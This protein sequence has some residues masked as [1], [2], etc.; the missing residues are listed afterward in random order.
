MLSQQRPGAR[1]ESDRWGGLAADGGPEDLSKE[2]ERQGRAARGPCG[3]GGGGGMVGERGVPRWAS[4]MAGVWTLPS[5]EPADSHHRG[6]LGTHAIMANR[7]PSRL[8]IPWTGPSP[9]PRAAPEDPSTRRGCRP[10]ARG[11]PS[12]SRLPSMHDGRRPNRPSS[13]SSSSIFGSDR[14]VCPGST[15]EGR[16]AATLSRSR[17]SCCNF[18]FTR[19][20]R[21]EKRQKNEKNARTSD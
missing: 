15:A 11:R 1:L 13:P 3:F 14:V 2:S 12:S 16:A 10:T 9:P 8:S 17:R 7:Q 21:T 5:P 4:P 19:P 18:V 20:P 6:P